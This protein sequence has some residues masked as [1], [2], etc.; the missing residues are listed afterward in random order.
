MEFLR[1]GHDWVGMLAAAIPSKGPV[2]LI[3]TSGGSEVSIDEGLRPFS[4][5]STTLSVAPHCMPYP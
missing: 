4:K 5:F 3:V 2:Q 1:I